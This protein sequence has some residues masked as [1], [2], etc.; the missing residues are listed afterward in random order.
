MRTYRSSRRNLLGSTREIHDSGISNLMANIM[1]EKWNIISNIKI[2]HWS[3]ILK[4][5]LHVLS[6]QQPWH[7][8]DAIVSHSSAIGCIKYQYPRSFSLV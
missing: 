6:N 5:G 4:K 2:E 7:S 8:V 1:F 3:S